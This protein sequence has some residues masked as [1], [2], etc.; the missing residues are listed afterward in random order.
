MR[1]RRSSARLLSSATQAFMRRRHL[2][3]I[4]IWVS[5]SSSSSERASSELVTATGASLATLQAAGS[6]ARRSR[7]WCR[8]ARRGQLSSR[9]TEGVSAYHLRVPGTSQSGVSTDISRAPKTRISRIASSPFRRIHEVFAAIRGSSMAGAPARSSDG[10]SRAVAGT[11]CCGW[12]SLL[13]TQ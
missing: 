10:Q 5:R 2:P 7:P 11:R 4:G 8:P 13:S 1:K 3:E 6:P 9:R 12:R